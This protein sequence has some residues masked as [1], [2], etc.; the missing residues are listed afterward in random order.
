MKI[1]AFV[2][3]AGLAAVALSAPAFSAIPAAD[4]ADDPAYN[5]FSWANGSNGGFGFLPWAIQTAPGAGGGNAGT[6]TQNVGNSGLQD[7]G[8][9]NRAWATFANGGNT[10]NKV[11]AHRR[12]DNTSS[13]FPASLV[14]LQTIAA[15]M[16]NSDNLNSGQTPGW[17]GMIFGSSGTIDPFGGGSTGTLNGAFGFGFRGGENTY[18]IYDAFGV[19]DTGLTFTNRGINVSFQMLNTLNGSYRATITPLGPSPQSPVVRNGQIFG[20]IDGFSFYNWGFNGGNGDDNF[21]NN[22][23]IVPTPGATALLGLA[24]LC[25]MRRRRQA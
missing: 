15:S 6:Y 13:Q 25:G 16:E 3:I 7:I 18:K 4:N 24:G 12:F 22:I 20:A 21:F 2:G 5:G 9:P 17:V 19:F 14:N 11:A 8:S 1:S 10:P 23:S